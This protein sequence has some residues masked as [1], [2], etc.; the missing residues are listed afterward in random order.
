MS[1]NFL[2]HPVEYCFHYIIELVLRE[3]LQIFQLIFS[4]PLC[5]H[6]RSFTVSYSFMKVTFDLVTYTKTGQIA[7]RDVSVSQKSL[8]TR[9]LG[10]I[11]ALK[12][13]FGF[14]EFE[15]HEKE[16]FFHYR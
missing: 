13:S 15:N 9:Q 12:E 1:N 4:V 2:R 3:S 5:S 14:I 7:A 16:V 6:L 11:C 10:F 8:P